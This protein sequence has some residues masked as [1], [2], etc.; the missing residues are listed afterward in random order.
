M[1][2][3]PAELTGR[4]KGLANLRPFA[5]GVSGNPGGMSAAR[6]ARQQV[7][8]EEDPEKLRQLLA[9]VCKRGIDGSDAAARLYCEVLGLLSK[10]A[11]A[12]IDLSKASPEDL[13]A[14]E[15]LAGLAS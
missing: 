3:T 10:D 5:P 1:A 7:L 4:A 9:A 14:A 11:P 15:R 12:N 13:A 8:S 2:E 6:R